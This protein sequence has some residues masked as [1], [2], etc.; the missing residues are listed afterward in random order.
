MLPF[1]LSVPVEDSNCCMYVEDNLLVVHLD[2]HILKYRA[3]QQLV[4]TSTSST[5]EE[6]VK[7]QNSQPV[8]NTALRLY[9]VTQHGICYSV[10]MD[11]GVVGP[12]IK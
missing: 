1:Q 5:Q 4:H 3:G 8:V 9:Y 6:G 11:T 7:W 10:S 12:A 2:H